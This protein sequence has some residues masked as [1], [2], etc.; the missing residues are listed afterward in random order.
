[1]A[2]R[3]K[4][5]TSSCGLR[6][7]RSRCLHW[8]KG[9]LL[10]A[11]GQQIVERFSWRHVAM[12]WTVHIHNRNACQILQI[13]GL[14]DR[15]FQVF[16][17]WCFVIHC[18]VLVFCLTKWHQ[19]LG[20]RQSDVRDK[21]EEACLPKAD[22]STFLFDVLYLLNS[23]SWNSRERHPEAQMSSNSVNMRK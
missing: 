5:S 17:Y 1:M 11:Y 21:T 7:Y 9:R 23:F 6:I 4:L 10:V 8:Q 16:K 18:V 3:K 14:Q 20:N 12:A 22:L 2:V 13:R 15:I 19:V